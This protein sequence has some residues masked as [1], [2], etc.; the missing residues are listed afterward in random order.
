MDPLEVPIPDRSIVVQN[1]APG[2]APWEIMSRMN[3]GRLAGF[4][5][6]RTAQVVSNELMLVP[7]NASSIAAQAR[8]FC[9]EVV[10]QSRASFDKALWTAHHDGNY[11][12]WSVTLA[13]WRPIEG[14]PIAGFLRPE[15][16][17][18]ELWDVAWR[19][20]DKDAIIP[21]LY[22][23][24]PAG[25]DP[26]PIPRDRGVWFA[27]K[28]THPYG[29]TA[30]A[31]FEN[32]YS[33]WELSRLGYQ[34][35]AGVV[36]MVAQLLT[37]ATLSD[38]ADDNRADELRGEQ[39]R[40]RLEGDALLRAGEELE[41]VDVNS[42]SGG[43]TAA[44]F[45]QECIR[46]MANVIGGQVDDQN[47]GQGAGQGLAGREVGSRVS[48]RVITTDAAILAKGFVEPWCYRIL[49][50]NFGPAVAAAATPYAHIDTWDVES[51]RQYQEGVK[52][53]W[54]MGIPQDERDVYKFMARSHPP[55]P[56]AKVVEGKAQ[57]AKTGS[58]ELD[59]IAED[60]DVR[61]GQEQEEAA[62]ASIID[63]ARRRNDWR[64]V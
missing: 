23:R 17:V 33:W 10:A 22:A 55:G 32:C 51:W 18:P 9:A 62:R 60:M 41:T 48:G 46:T 57:T 3:T 21:Q 8:D 11:A 42:T 20:P 6:S 36:A 52:N 44:P 26:V 47:L 56:D 15:F 28:S 43:N 38:D 63:R 58:A 12:G 37:K 30:G 16:E 24:R 2:E 61:P 1:S 50:K 7:R 40:L 49:A 45:V 19:Y 25:K 14:G 5:L 31:G 54:E 64:V 27:P 35:W 13:G 39:S 59:E 4:T 53:I 29:W 34:D